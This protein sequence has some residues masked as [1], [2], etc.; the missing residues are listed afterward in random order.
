MAKRVLIAD[1]S[2]IVRDIIKEFLA[3]RT[4]A[5]VC[6]EASNGREAVQQALTLK[7][8]LMLLDLSMPE[9]NGAEV[10]SVLKTQMPGLA[11]ILFTMYGEHI[12]QSLAA[13][14]GIDLVLSKPDGMGK[15]VEFV[16]LVLS[17]DP[18]SPESL[19]SEEAP[20]PGSARFS[21]AARAVAAGAAAPTG[22][23]AATESTDPKPDATRTVESSFD[24]PASES[25]T[26]Y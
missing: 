17:R 25:T 19:S 11:I 20:G 6:G 13:A 26:A 24:A 8:D 1:D 2:S 21:T 14:T 23:A 4:D 22:V 10:A 9:L 18:Q 16:N 5:E 15:L 3:E 7:P 12:G